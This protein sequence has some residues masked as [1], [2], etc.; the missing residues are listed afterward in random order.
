MGEEGLVFLSKSLEKFVK[1][2][3]KFVKVGYFFGEDGYLLKKNWQNSLISGLFGEKSIKMWSW[4]V[5]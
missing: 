5:F 3:E 2:G 4:G 1:V